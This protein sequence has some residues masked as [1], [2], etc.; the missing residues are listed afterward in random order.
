MDHTRRVAVLHALIG[1]HGTN[2]LIEAIVQQGYQIDCLDEVLVQRVWTKEKPTVPG[3]YWWKDGV[4]EVSVLH[5]VHLPA[6]QQ[7]PDGSVNLWV[8][9]VWEDVVTGQM[10][11]A[12]D[13]GEWQGPM[14]PQA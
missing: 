5:L 7:I 14:E 9:N 8:D 3:W 4:G 6:D 10:A 13:Y 11:L 2:I 1:K 12:P